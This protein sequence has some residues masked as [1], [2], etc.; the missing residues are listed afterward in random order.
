MMPTVSSAILAVSESPTAGVELEE[1]IW[2][3][4]SEEDKKHH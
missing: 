3:S 1:T 2:T 4:H